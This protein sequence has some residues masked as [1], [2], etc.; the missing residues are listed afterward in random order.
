[1]FLYNIYYNIYIFLIIMYILIY[2]LEIT[3]GQIR[4]LRL[5]FYEAN[6]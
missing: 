5:D 6:I 1:M 3:F 2:I 4:E